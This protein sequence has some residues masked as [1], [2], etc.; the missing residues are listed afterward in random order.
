[1][2]TRKYPFLEKKGFT[3][4]SQLSGGYLPNDY[5]VT[6]ESPYFFMKYGLEKFTAFMEIS[7]ISDKDN[8]HDLALVKALL[9]NEEVSNKKPDTAELENFLQTDFD[10][11]KILFDITNYPQTKEKLN[12]LVQIRLQQMFPGLKDRF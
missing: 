11:I 4:T 5:V 6:L 12:D 9:Y 7:S 1:M 3:V 8:W 10:K 2:D